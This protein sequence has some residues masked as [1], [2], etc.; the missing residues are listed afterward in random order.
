M[1]RIHLLPQ[2]QA[3]SD[4][5]IAWKTTEIFEVYFG[6]SPRRTSDEGRSYLTVMT[7]R[8]YE[9]QRRNRPKET[10]KAEVAQ[11]VEH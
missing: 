9:V 4:A 8:E 3:K 2:I 6:V 1:V 7:D 5:E 10:K 11:L